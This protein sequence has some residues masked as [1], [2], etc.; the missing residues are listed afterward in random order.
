MQPHAESLS[1][2][3]SFLELPEKK[4]YSGFKNEKD[5]N[6]KSFIKN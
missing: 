4:D 2:I 5:P 3:L 1:P 6:L